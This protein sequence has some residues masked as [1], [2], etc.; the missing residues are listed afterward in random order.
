MVRCGSLRSPEK[1]VR[2]ILGFKR[3]TAEGFY[4]RC[5]MGVPVIFNHA[6]FR[7]IIGF[8]EL[9]D[10]KRLIYVRGIISNYFLRKQVF[11][12]RLERAGELEVSACKK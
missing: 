3:T 8:V 10:I 4:V 5:K 6:D 7:L 2:A 9:K 12:Q 1:T 11:L